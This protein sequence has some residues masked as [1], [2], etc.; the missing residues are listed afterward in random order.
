MIHKLNRPL[1]VLAMTCLTVVALAQ[2]DAKHPDPKLHYAY[3]L[4]G[5][6]ETEKLAV[7]W[8]GVIRWDKHANRNEL[9]IQ[10]D[11]RTFLI[12]D[13]ATLAAMKEATRPLR[14]SEIQ[15]KAGTEEW[16][17]AREKER[18]EVYTKTDKIVQDALSKGLGEPAKPA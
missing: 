7:N 13:S 1:V 10:R 6:F 8:D 9:W 15:Q 12:L 3:R 11:N 16:H 18:A 2:N 4:V 5:L 17:K 14:I